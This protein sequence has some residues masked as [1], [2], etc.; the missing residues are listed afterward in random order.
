VATPGTTAGTSVRW[1][2]AAH[3]LFF[4]LLLATAALSL[5]TRRLPQAAVTV[6][7]TTALAVWYT[8]LVARERR[9]P[10]RWSLAGLAS[11]SAGWVVWLGLVAQDPLYLVLLAILYPQIGWRLR[12]PWSI[13]GLVILTLLWTGEL[14]IGA[15]AFAAPLL[16]AFGA[17]AISILITLYI[18]AVLGE[19]HRR[20]RLLA[21]LEATRNELAAAERLAGTIE[22]RQRLA[23][24]IHDTVAQGLA[25]AVLHLESAQQALSPAGSEACHDV[26]L[27]LRSVRAS[28]SEAR[29]LTGSLQ[30]AALSSDSLGAALA[31]LMGQWSEDQGVGVELRVTGAPV[32]IRPEAAVTLVRATQESLANVAKHAGASA[33]S[34][35]LSYLDGLVALDVHDDGR[36]FQ[37]EAGARPRP[38]L[39]GTGF[40]L[41]GLRRR[42][43]RQGGSVAIES[44]AG[45]GT[46]IAVSIPVAP[47]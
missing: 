24:E 20:G 19:S 44:A 15:H 5:A 32:A 39:D 36:G 33:V 41:T 45:E 27:A 11:L 21:E 47:S 30:P 34:V 37:P 8:L 46:T 9:R 16:V 12:M 13:A 1:R 42:V 17:G 31:E 18:E 10:E 6:T 38:A 3:V 14:A 35:T 4:A 43:E 25:G 23:G 28:L 2:P 7:L 22:E 40:G 26:E 29:G